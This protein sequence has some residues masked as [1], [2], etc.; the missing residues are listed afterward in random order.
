MYSQTRSKFQSLNISKFKVFKPPPQAMSLKLASACPAGYECDGS[1]VQLAACTSGYYALLNDGVCT[2]CPAGSY[3]A[4]NY[5][6][7]LACSGTGTE[8]Y[9]PAGST[10]CYQCP[11]GKECP[12]IS[13]TP[14]DCSSG[15]YSLL[16]D[17][18]CTTCPAGSKCASLDQSPVSCSSGEYSA[19]G[20][21]SCITCQAG[22]YCASTTSSPV[23]CS[24]TGLEQYAL[25]GQ[26]SCSQCPAGYSCPDIYSIPTVCS[27]GYYALAGDRSCTQ[28]PAGSMCSTTTA[29][30]VACSSGEYSSAGAISCTQCP[31]GYKCPSTT[32]SPSQCSGT[33]LEQYSLAGQTSCSECP[34]GYSCPDIY[35]TPAACSSGQY[36]LAGELTCTSCPAGSEC[37]STTASPTTCSTGY[38]SL[39]GAAA[40]TQ[41]P[42]GYECPSASSSPSVC[43]SGYYSLDGQSSCTQCPAGSKCPTTTVAPIACLG[44]GLEQYSVAGSTVCSQCPAGYEC[45]TTSSAPTACTTGYYSLIGGGTCIQCPAGSE[46]TSTSISP[47]ACSSGSYSLAGQ[48]SCTTCPAGSQCPSTS[49]SPVACSSGEY[50]LSGSISCTTCLAGYKCPSTSSSPTQCSGTG[51]E[52]YSLAGSTSCSQCPAGSSCSDIYSTPVACT[53]GYYSL[54]G[55]STCTQCPAGSQCPTTS[56]SP[57][58]CSSGQYALSGATSC[59]PCPIGYECP[60]TN[61]S[62]TACTSGYYASSTLQT[63]CTQCPAGSQCPSTTVN[64]VACTSGQYSLAGYTTCEPCPAGFKCPTTSVAPIQCSGTGLEQYSLSGA[65][66]CSQCSAGFS[67]PDIY[68]TPIACSFGTY[69]LAGGATCISCPAGSECPSTSSSPVSCNSGYYSLIGGGT[70]IACPKGS[71]CPNNNE[72]PT[73]CEDGYYQSATAQSTCIICSVGK[74][75]ADKTIDP[76]VCSGSPTEQ[77]S[78]GEVMACQKCP[79]GYACPTVYVKTACAV[80]TY[81]LEG[82]AVCNTCP[83]GYGCTDPASSPVACTSSQYSLPGISECLLC[84]PGYECPTTLMIPQLC[85]EGYYSKQGDG[86]CSICPAGYSCLKRTSDPVACSSGY[87]SIQGQG[88]CDKCPTGYY[89]PTTTQSPF[90]CPAGSYSLSGQS[91]C[92][93]CPVGKF[94]PATNTPQAYDCPSGYYASVTNQVSCTACP[95][96][97]SCSDPTV[98]PVPCTEGY[99]SFGYA[100]T[101]TQCPAGFYCPKANAQPVLCPAG[102]QSAAG[103]SECLEC[104]DGVTCTRSDGII[105]DPCTSGQYRVNDGRI[106]ICRDCPPGHMCPTITSQPIICPSGTFAKFAQTSCTACAAEHFCPSLGADAQEQC[107]PGTFQPLTSKTY[108]NECPPGHYCSSTLVASATA[109]PAG[110]F[111]PY[112]NQTSCLSCPAGFFCPTEGLTVPIQCP[113]GYYSSTDA[114]Q[115]TMCEAG[116]ACPSGYFS[117]RYSCESGSFS[118][119][120]STYCFQCPI[121]KSCLLSGSVLTVQNCPLGYYSDMGSIACSQCPA[122]KSCHTMDSLGIIDCESGWYSLIGETNCQPCPAGFMCPNKDGTGIAQCSDGEFAPIGSSKCFTCPKGNYCPYKHI[123]FIE[124]CPPG[125]YSTGNQNICKECPEHYECPHRDSKIDVKDGY[126]SPKG[127]GVALRCRA[128]WYCSM[129]STPRVVRPCEPGYYSNTGSSSCTACPIG[130]SCY[131]QDVYTSQ[132]TC[133]EGY[134]QDEAGKTYCKKCLDKTFKTDRSAE[135]CSSY[136][137]GYEFIFGGFTQQKQCPYGSYSTGATVTDE[138]KLVCQDCQAGGICTTGATSDVTTVSC[139]SGFWCNHLQ[140]SNALYAMFPCPPGYKATGLTNAK[141][142]D[143]ACT[144]CTAGVYCE[145]ANTPEQ[146]CIKGHYCPAFTTRATQYPCPAGTYQDQLGKTAVSDCITCQSTYYCPQ[147]SSKQ[148]Q[149]PPG[150]ICNSTELREYQMVPCPAG[151]YN[152]NLGQTTCVSCPLGA[153]CPSGSAY[154]QLCPPGTYNDQP[155]QKQKTDCKTCPDNYVCSVFGL[156]DYDDISQPNIEAGYLSPAGVQYAQQLPCPPGTIDNDK[157]LTNINECDLCPAGSACELGTALTAYTRKMVICE[158]GYYCP[159]GTLHDKQYPCPGGTY[160]AAHDLT[161]STQCNQCPAGYFCPPGS[162]KPFI[163]P[164]GYF[165]LAGTENFQHSPCSNGTYSYKKGLTSAIE[166]TICPTGHFCREHSTQPEK[167]P[168][169]TYND[170]QGAFIADNSIVSNSGSIKTCKICSEGYYCPTEGMSAMIKCPK[171]TYSPSGSYICLE[172]QEGHDCQTTDG[173]TF[174]DYKA[175]KNTPNGYYSDGVVQ[176]ICPPGHFCPTATKIYHQCPSGTYMPNSLID[177]VNYV[178]NSQSNQCIKTPAGYFTQLRASTSYSDNICE[179]GYYCPEGSN[180]AYVNRCP[181]GFYTDEFQSTSCKTCPAGYYCDEYNIYPVICPQGYYCP[182]Q[183]YEPT[184]CSKGTFGSLLGNQAS[185]DCLSCLPGQYC[186][187]AGLSAPDGLCDPGYFCKG[188]AYKA[189]PTDGITGDVCTAGG[190]CEYGSK[191]V[192]ECPPGT[193]NP[194]TKAKTQTDC[195]QCLPGYYCAGA[196]LPLPTAKCEAGYYCPSGSSNSKQL[197]SPPGYFS[198]EGAASPTICPQGTYNQFTSKSECTKC[199]AGFYCDEEGM[200]N[201]IKDCSRGNYCPESSI[202]PTKCP[203]GTYNNQ[204]NAQKLADCKQ[205]LP[206]KYCLYDGLI[207]PSGDC[208]QGYY[209]ISG[210]SSKTPLVE[211]TDK[212]SGPCPKG[213]YCKV[214]TSYPIPCPAGT[215]SDSFYA[216]NE[217]TCKPCTV[218]YYCSLAGQSTPYGPCDAGFYCPAGQKSPKPESYYCLPGYY[219][220]KQ[221][222]M[223]QKV[224]AGYFQP[225]P[226][227]STYFKCPQG[228]YCEEGTSDYSTNL[229]PVGHRCPEGTAYGQQYP[230]SSGYYQPLKGQYTCIMCDPGKYCGNQGLSAPSADC[231][232]GFYCRAGSPFDSPTGTYNSINIGGMCQKGYYCP[233]GTAFMLPCT[234]GMYCPQIGLAASELKCSA[235]YYCLTKAII[236]TPVTESDGGGICPQGFY[237]PE[238]SITPLPC[239]ISTY[240]QN[241]GNIDVSDC[242]P[243]PAG[244]YCDS[245]GMSSPSGQCDAGYYCPQGSTSPRDPDHICPLG[246]KCAQGSIEP[247]ECDSYTYQDTLGNDECK[248]CPPGYTCTSTTIE[249]CGQNHYCPSSQDRATCPDGRFTYQLDAYSINDCLPCLPGYYCKD[250]ADYKLVM[251]PCPAGV[252]C[253]GEVESAAGTALCPEG[254]YCELGT[255]Q[256]KGCPPGKYC[257]TTGLSAPVGNCEAGYY[258]IQNSS[259]STPSDGIQGDQCPRGY[260]CPA[261]TFSPLACP[262]GTYNSKIGMEA[263]TDCLNCPSGFVCTERGQD[264]YDTVCPEGFYCPG[265]TSV[266]QCPAGYYCPNRLKEPIKCLSG[267]YQPNVQQSACLECPAG[268][269]CSQLDTTTLTPCPEGSYCPVRTEEPKKCPVGTYNPLIGQK[270]LLTDCVPCAQGYYCDDEGLTTPTGLCSDGYY[271]LNSAITATPVDTL[272]QKKFGECLE[273]FYCPSGTEA[274]IPCPIGTINDLKKQSSVSACLSCPEGY[275]CDRL[276]ATRSTYGI[277]ILSTTYACAPGFL[278]TGGAK[279]QKPSLQTGQGGELCSEGHYCK[280]GESIECSVLYHSP[281]KGAQSC[282]GCPKGKYCDITAMTTPKECPSGHYCLEV[283]ATLL[284][285]NG[286]NLN[287][288]S[289]GTYSEFTG[290]WSQSECTY[291]PEGQY[292]LGGGTLPD[293][294]CDAG[295]YCGVGSSI[296]TPT[297]TKYIMGNT[298]PR[299]GQ[300]PPGYYCPQGTVAPLPCPIGTYNPDY[301]QVVCKPCL[302][303]HYCDEKGLDGITVLAKTCDPGYYCIEGAIKPSPTDGVTGRLCAKGNYCTGALIEQQCAAGYYEPRDG[304]YKCQKCY[305]G[306]ICPKGSILPTPCPKGKYCPEDAQDPINCPDGTYGQTTKIWDASQCAVCPVGQYCNEGVIKGTCA[307]GY[308]CDQGAVQKTDSDKLC[309]QSHYC[310]EGTTLPKRCPNGGMTSTRGAKTPTDCKECGPGYYCLENGDTMNFCPKGYYC[311]GYLDPIECPTF[312]YNNLR[313]MQDPTACINCPAGYFCNTTAISNYEYYPCPKGYYCPKEPSTEAIICPAGTYNSEGYGDSLKSCLTCPVGFYC[314]AGTINPVPCKNGTYCPKGSSKTSDCPSGTYCPTMIGKQQSCPASFYCPTSASDQYL[315]CQNGTYCGTSSSSQT[316]CPNGFYGSSNPNNV[317]LDKGCIGCDA[318]YYSIQGKNQCN[319]CTP[320]Y[321]CLGNTSTATPTSI[322]LHGGYECPQGYYCPEGSYQTY[323]CPRGSY[324]SKTK[325]TSQDDCTKCPSGQYSDVIALKSCKKCTGYTSSVEGSTSCSC[326]G[327]NRVY[328]AQTGKCVC[329]AGFEPADKTANE[330]SDVDCV[331]RIYDTCTES[332]IQ[333][334][335][336]VCKDKNDCSAECNGGTGTISAG[337]GICQCDDQTTAVDVCDSA[338]MSKQKQVTFNSNGSISIYDPVTKTTSISSLNQTGLEGSAQCSNSDTSYCQLLSLSSTSSGD[339]AADFSVPSSLTKSSTS[340]RMLTSRSRYLQTSQNYVSNPVVCMPGGSALIFEEISKSHYPVYMKDSLINTNSNFDYSSFSVL[341]TK[342]LNGTKI[343]KFV[344]TFQDSG[345]YVFGDS[346]DNSRQTIISV[347]PSSQKCPS[348]LVYDAKTQ[349]NLLKVGVS[350]NKDIIFSPDWGFFIGIVAA[351]LGLILITVLT[352]GYVYRK[353]WAMKAYSTIGYQRKHYSLIKIDDPSDHDAIISINADTESF[354]FLNE[355][356]DLIRTREQKKLLEEEDRK[357]KQRR[358]KEKKHQVLDLEEVEQLKDRLNKHLSE[359]KKLFGV[360]QTGDDD[361]NEELLGGDDEENEL[362]AQKLFDQISKLKELIEDN[363]RVLEGDQLEDSELNAGQTE[364]EKEKLEQEKKEREEKLRKEQEEESK[365]LRDIEYQKQQDNKTEKNQK[366][367]DS[368]KNEVLEHFEKD[369]DRRKQD[370]LDRMQKMGVTLTVEEQNAMMQQFDDNLGR[371][372]GLLEEDDGYQQDMLKRKIEERKNRRRKLQENLSDQEKALQKKQEA[373]NDQKNEIE[374]EAKD[375]NAQLDAE[376]LQ[377][378]I[379]KKQGIQEDLEKLK[380]EKLLDY[381]DKLKESKNTK[382]FG[383]VLDEYQD[384]SKRVDQ[385]LEKEKKKQEAELERQLKNRKGQRRAQIEMEKAEKLRALQGIQDD[386]TEADRKGIDELKNLI[387]LDEGTKQTGNALD[388]QIDKI[389]QNVNS[390]SD[391]GLSRKSTL[392]GAIMSNDGQLL[393]PHSSN[394][395]MNNSS[396]MLDKMKKG[397]MNDLDKKL[398]QQAKERRDMEKK[399][400]EEGQKLDDEVDRA[401]SDNMQDLKSEMAKRDELKRKLSEGTSSDLEKQQIIDQLEKAEENIKNKIDQQNQEQNSTLAKK[402]EARRKRKQELAEQE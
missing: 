44:T 270:N 124:Q 50:A 147:G 271:C 400:I 217:S 113:V 357:E 286:T 47:V 315:K 149:C 330:N 20:A 37:P 23:Q 167:C 333:D 214:G 14:T 273:G 118:Y 51:L 189:D 101:C 67:C 265:D 19:A 122:G 54:A 74:Q 104:P 39:G 213:Y 295:Y 28:C 84:P 313:G 191:R 232:A 187:Q 323:A 259:S 351:V 159:T 347:M 359:I 280:S 90:K 225:M 155:E 381:E 316:N 144:Q 64:P 256:P 257:N 66:S 70:C 390:M 89:C 109:C 194:N 185:T 258:C 31:A 233:S 401:K 219:C 327:S 304:S 375:Q 197:T 287:P 35:T 314:Q 362:R 76:V 108:C 107:P 246:H 75:C 30:P 281:N 298:Q 284:N 276:G 205:C 85:Q 38:Y 206:G 267:Q 40:C 136:T 373:F 207:E 335:Y 215:Y 196:N 235:G 105:Q 24:G 6:S 94:C 318:G 275:Y 394:S 320:G 175:N 291:C 307:A 80:G 227:Q 402:L 16:G 17:T 282:L 201:N 294:L 103:Q 245:T 328:L 289:A 129:T 384:A 346:A 21:T 156:T 397:L 352:I 141:T 321:V 93:D 332:Q 324:G 243:C 360:D 395:A 337:I 367:L 27:S 18:G 177:S 364:E 338:C 9:S 344:F 106:E 152:P 133:P 382:D 348:N 130:S 399:M 59:T 10:T 97:Y 143:E 71:K 203:A 120:S 134:Y 329:K 88:Y 212:T 297:T 354:S 13:A 56:A 334:Q 179:L 353:S 319:L 264:S 309:P 126:F 115:C 41:C 193:Y 4:N 162:Y 371:I 237:C 121:G 57:T 250:N 96:G 229:C 192:K 200:S 151:F 164:G 91:S 146:T 132:V 310:L 218:G 145:G 58:A 22:Y 388:K 25:A 92:T 253:L 331:E 279:N 378:R 137:D 63:A 247:I 139:Y 358:D 230:C 169:G 68:T 15:E 160:S 46:C 293:G 300:C 119:A 278:C 111:A 211:N 392:R 383:K 55:E 238:A 355:G 262:I 98:N 356:K 135:T 140:G 240:S 8:Q 208:E 302:L 138:S 174:T 110:K 223:P 306:Y 226:Y 301:N 350:V 260:Y 342:L 42:A 376:I 49:T 166:C 377:E 78:P 116:Y 336:G 11:A 202:T 173:I 216:I 32:S 183:T 242:S 148:I 239:P 340:K 317:N 188:G 36:S 154:P 312:T 372:G 251:Q 231:T 83:F 269:Y 325:L 7:P 77:Y 385:E 369:M 60:N 86:K 157:N 386:Q 224:P 209:C 184:P 95:A 368:K 81:A 102:K 339:F 234:P 33:G 343:D 128:G 387:A 142:R 254:F 186:S 180:N 274:M 5:E 72:L 283:T 290:L 165:C 261:G 12:S 361:D 182:A 198:L 172:C 379:V 393:S 153:F 252:Y 241:Q 195:I 3:C 87:F 268:F 255:S 249:L 48:T 322:S 190:F 366:Q 69:S 62:P 171:G 178:G 199:R 2:Q 123:A 82:D 299:Q 125:T 345:V 150:T 114:E 349:A 100:G 396:L 308:Y 1:G 170:V 220:P 61:Q 163:C 365:R 73:T 158:P 161:L 272:K 65:T 277:D 26:T 248:D 43:S 127:T 244:L 236:A 112:G 34:A 389:I 99:Y 363:R 79:A 266:I 181:R 176:Y 374:Q 131:L 228:Y 292:C 296:Q 391:Q 53:S 380:M 221:S 168:K 303:G 52:Q 263:L 341:E 305:Q 29:S 117:D 370:M 326:I 311:F 285:N 204:F 45:P 398:Q 222:G 210:S 288:C